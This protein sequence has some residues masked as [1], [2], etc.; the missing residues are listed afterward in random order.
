MVIQAGVVSKWTNDAQ[1]FLLEHFD[2]IC[3]SPSHIYHSALPL[4]PSS[5][6]LQ[7]CYSAEL[8]VMVKVVKGLPAEWGMCSR[9]VSLGS[10]TLDLSYH[11]NTIAVGSVPGDILILNTIT[12]SQTSVLSGHTKEVNSLTFSS[13]GTSLVSGSDD[14]TVKLWDI[15]TGG[16]VKT[17]SGHHH[18]VYSVSISA[19]LTKIASGSED[20]TIHLWDIQTGECHCTIKQQDTVLWIAFSPIDPQHLISVCDGKIWQWDTNGH[21]IKPPQN[22]SHVTFSPDGTHFVSCNGTAVTIQ[23]S[24]SG[25]IVTEFHMANNKTNNCCFSPDGRLV[26]ATA[27]NTVYVW[28]ITSPDPQPVETF[29]GHTKVVTSLTF[30]SSSSL[31]SASEDQSIKFWDIGTLS[32]GPVVADPKFTSF[33]PALIKSVTLQAKDGI[34]ITS[35]SDGMVKTWDISTGLCKRSFQT[36][37][38]DSPKRDVQL[39]NGKLIFVWYS[40]SKIN[41]WDAE[42]GE[43]LWAVDQVFDSYD[44]KISGDGSRV[45]SLNIFYIVAWSV[46]TGEAVGRVELEYSM[47]RRSLTVDSSSIWVYCPKSGYQGWDFGIPGSLPVQLP[48]VPPHRL[49]PSG[50]MLWDISLS[51]LKDRTTG[52]VVFRLSKGFAAP[53][54]VQWNGQYLV[55]CYPPKE[56]LILDFSHFLLH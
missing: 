9:T 26:A 17:F 39:I 55:V 20:K 56:V 49:H 32:K 4:S 24:K 2:A 5:S 46:Q 52:K 8:S 36:P 42:K 11:N 19:D 38:K 22:G 25:M 40:D 41:I 18:R 16:A 13:D 47:Y 15:Q 35:D 54:D 51:R 50:T 12:G 1:H 34:I 33:T 14:R 44:L 23:D 28:D 21:Q 7:K 10:H 3:D 43:L 29:I 48:D 6:W 27:D 31:I 53:I 45:F 37:T 30:P